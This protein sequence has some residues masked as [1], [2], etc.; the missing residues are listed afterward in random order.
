MH[1]VLHHFASNVRTPLIIV[2][3]WSMSTN[4]TTQN[5]VI[6]SNVDQCPLIPLNS[7]WGGLR[8]FNRHWEGSRINAW[9]LI[10]IDQH[11]AMIRENP[12]MYS[13]TWRF[14]WLCHWLHH[15]SKNKFLLK[16]L[17][18]KISPLPE[19]LNLQGLGFYFNLWL[20]EKHSASY[21]IMHQNP[22]PWE[23]YLQ[24]SG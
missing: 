15:H 12:E 1:F 17:P 18:V 11:W 13:T 20:A 5:C 3:C 21:P 19:F 4:H 14:Q 6:D 7:T 22:K 2:Q 8:G 10:G 23:V 16:H 24:S 9:I